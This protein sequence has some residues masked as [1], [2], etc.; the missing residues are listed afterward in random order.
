MTTQEINPRWGQTF[1]AGYTHSPLEH[2][3]LGYQWW[4]DGRLYFPGFT[5]NHSLSLYGGFQHM[6]HKERNYSNKILYP[7]G[8]TLPGYEI[9]SLR[10]GYH[11]PIAF[12]DLPLSSLL[13]QNYKRRRI[14]RLG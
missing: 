13:S 14:L 8:I 4:G 5:T 3:D 10:T 11:M 6:S 2:I 7:R 1:S 12:P 9:A